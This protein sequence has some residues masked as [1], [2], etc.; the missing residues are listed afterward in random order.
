M[1]IFNGKKLIEVDNME[2][3]GFDSW[4]NNVLYVIKYIY[5]IK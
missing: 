4:C 1:I 5:V 3:I 2:W